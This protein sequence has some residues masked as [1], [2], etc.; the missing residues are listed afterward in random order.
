MLLQTASKC[1][2]SF[3]NW[4]RDVYDKPKW[5]LLRIN[6]TVYEI[7]INGR[8]DCTISAMYP[9]V[10]QVTRTANGTLVPEIPTLSG[11]MFKFAGVNWWASPE[12][13]FQYWTGDAKASF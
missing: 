13:A 8:Y 11:G 3:E 5:R 4:F 10:W 7:H 12:K 6:E 1:L 9:N 2:Q